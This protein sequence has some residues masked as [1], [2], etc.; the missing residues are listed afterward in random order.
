MQCKTARMTAPFRYEQTKKL[1]FVLGF[2]WVALGLACSPRPE[3][4][5]PGL[6]RFQIQPL[7]A[8]AGGLWFVTSNYATGGTLGRVD[9]NSGAVSGDLGIVGSDVRLHSDGQ[10]LVVLSRFYPDSVSLIA[11]P[12]GKVH[13]T[14]SLPANANAQAVARDGS[15]QW[16][17]AYQ[18]LDEVHAFDGNGVRVA[19]VDLSSMRFGNSTLD[20]SALAV[21]PNGQ[22]ALL[23]QRL[24]RSSSR[25]VPSPQSSIGFIDREKLKVEASYL[26]DVSNPLA[27]AARVANEDRRSASGIGDQLVIAGA[28]DLTL[29]AGHKGAIESFLLQDIG[30]S[31]KK[32]NRLSPESLIVA[33]DLSFEKPLSIAWYPDENKSCINAGTDEI[34]CEYSARSKGYVFNAVAGAQGIIFVSYIADSKAELWAIDPIRKTVQRIRVSA[35]IQSISSGP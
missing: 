15:N 16:W 4:P 29:S 28:G 22:L 1:W 23:G 7:K 12:N 27:M 10:N 18:N 32:G 14:W 13:Q 2:L 35:P 33:V 3:R 20:A 8:E 19:Q 31:S 5:D 17:I 34:L 21:F 6:G 26:V 30:F 9:L 24:Q 25:W 11:E